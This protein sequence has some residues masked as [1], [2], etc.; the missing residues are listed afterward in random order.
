[1]RRLFK[2]VSLLCLCNLW[3]QCSYAAPPAENQQAWELVFSDEFNSGKINPHHWQVQVKAAD[4]NSSELQFYANDAVSVTNG[5]LRIKA[6]KRN[7]VNHGYTSGFL[8]SKGLLAQQ[9]G[10]FEMRAKIPSGKGLWPAFW[11]YSSEPGHSDEI[12]IMEAIGHD[13]HTIHMTQ[14]YWDWR[15]QKT[16]SIHGQH[17]G[18][19]YSKDFHLYGMWWT[20]EK[21]V[22]YV[23]G[24][25]YH[26]S[27]EAIPNNPMFI[28]V[29]MAVGGSWPGS[30]TPSTAFPASYDIDYIRIYQEANKADSIRSSD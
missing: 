15:L 21:I 12:D 6:E 16:K 26:Q 22:W 13:P 19:D 14:H 30:P 18:I 10:Y 28:L 23:D 5:T 1:M 29:N 4:S 3:M 25:P 11:L 17:T 27:R 24:T 7:V 2:A 9:Y 8:T 20:P